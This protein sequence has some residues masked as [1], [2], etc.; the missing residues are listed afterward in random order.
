MDFG[1]MGSLVTERDTQTAI[2]A[3]RQSGSKLESRGTCYA[4]DEEL[5]GR[6]FCNAD[7]RDEWERL[8]KL[9]SRQRC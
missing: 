7:C 9:R 2:A 8:Q 4:C 5:K 3:A 6:L 1:D